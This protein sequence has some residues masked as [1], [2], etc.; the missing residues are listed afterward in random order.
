MKMTY[1]LILQLFQELCNRIHSARPSRRPSDDCQM[2]HFR[3]KQIVPVLPSGSPDE[4]DQVSLSALLLPDLLESLDVDPDAPLPPVAPC[5]D[6]F[7][8]FRVAREV[9]A[10]A[11]TSISRIE[12][13]SQATTTLT[14]FEV[15]LATLTVFAVSIYEYQRGSSPGV[16]V[17]QGPFLRYG[18]IIRQLEQDD[19]P[20]SSYQIVM[21]DFDGSLGRFL[22]KQ[23]QIATL[24]Y[25]KFAAIAGLDCPMLDLEI[26]SYRARGLLRIKVANSG[27][28][29]I[30]TLI[31]QLIS[32]FCMAVEIYE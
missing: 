2:S 15:K 21:F 7:R 18:E 17:R 19:C 23:T 10:S 9:P 12:S 31:Q 32:A 22:D 8:C 3:L 1:I 25:E 14:C 28:P 4:S 24:F 20:T 13:P 30:E 6:P 27:I 29:G 11:E 5:E 16:V 26:V